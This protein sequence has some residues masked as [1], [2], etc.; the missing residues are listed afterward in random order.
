MKQYNTASSAKVEDK[1]S[2]LKNVAEIPFIDISV[3][4]K[5]SQSISVEPSNIKID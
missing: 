1:V 3:V 5:L 4:E 2:P